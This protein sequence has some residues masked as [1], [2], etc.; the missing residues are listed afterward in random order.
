MPTLSSTNFFPSTTAGVKIRRS[1]FSRVPCAHKLHVAFLLGHTTDAPFSTNK[2]E[3]QIQRSGCSQRLL[4]ILPTQRSL[5]CPLL[6]LRG[7]GIR[8][9]RCSLIHRQQFLVFSSVTGCKYYYTGT[10]TQI[11]SYE[12]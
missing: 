8:S 9:T 12:L 3:S 4:Q 1:G 7:H 2:P 5:V 10:V 6:H 11:S